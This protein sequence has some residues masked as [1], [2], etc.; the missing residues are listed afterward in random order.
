MQLP[1]LWDGSRRDASGGP[2]PFRGG[3]LL[4]TEWNVLRS[5]SHFLLLAGAPPSQV[6]RNSHPR[7]ASSSWGGCLGI[8]GTGVFWGYDPNHVPVIISLPF[9]ITPLEAQ[10]AIRC[11]QFPPTAVF[12]TATCTEYHRAHFGLKSKTTTTTK[13]KSFKPRSLGGTPIRKETVFTHFFNEC[14]LAFCAIW[15]PLERG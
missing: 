15:R 12:H 8:L 7:P 1:P 2:A 5:R 10:P 4:A 14:A 11:F 6:P 13:P 3:S 9:L